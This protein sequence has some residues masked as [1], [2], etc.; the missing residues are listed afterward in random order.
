MREYIR[1]AILNFFRK[2][3]KLAE[4]LIADAGGWQWIEIVHQNRPSGWLDKLFWKRKEVQA[5][6]TKLELVKKRLRELIE[7][8]KSERVKIIDLGCGSGRDIIETLSGLAG[9][10]EIQVIC[11]DSDPKAL[12]KGKELAENEGVADKI[13]FQEADLHR[14]I[15]EAIRDGN[16]YDIVMAVGILEF[17]ENA[18]EFLIRIGNVIA[19]HGTILTTHIRKTLGPLPALLNKS[20]GIWCPIYRDR[21]ELEEILKNVFEEVTIE[22]EPKKVYSIAIGKR[23]KGNP[24]TDFLNQR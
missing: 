7:E 15:E 22:Y 10:T 19:P 12:A 5:S 18:T 1:E 3:S 14:V 16:K 4:K 20:F 23:F 17:I 6:R 24:H 8:C 13:L 2:R 9:T 11:I 21:E